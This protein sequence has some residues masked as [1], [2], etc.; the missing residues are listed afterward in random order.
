M[1]RAVYREDLVRRK[2]SYLCTALKSFL[3]TTKSTSEVSWQELQTKIRDAFSSE[4]VDVDAMKLLLSS[5]SSNREDWQAF[6]KF[7]PHRLA[8][9]RLLAL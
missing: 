2:E 1:R 9:V 5:Y 4:S 6:A 7:D 8:S 3:M